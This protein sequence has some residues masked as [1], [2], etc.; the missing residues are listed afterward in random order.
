MIYVHL[1]EGFEEIEA[2][3]AVDVLRRAS[4][5]VQTVSVTGIELL[6]GLTVCR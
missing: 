5:D 3:T 4:I 2:L 6:Q 1:A